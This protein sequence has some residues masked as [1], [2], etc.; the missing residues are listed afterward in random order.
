MRIHLSLIPKEIID[1][2]D[3]MKYVETDGYVYVEITG[4]MYGLSQSKHITNQDIRKHLAKYR[5]YPTKRTLGFWKHQTQ[6]ISFTLVVDDFVIKYTNNY[7]IDD[8]F[9][10]IKEKYPL[11]IDWTGAK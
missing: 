6:P 9:K 10:A 8:L 4:A 2:Y 3:V 1:K 7:D 11:K 5:Y